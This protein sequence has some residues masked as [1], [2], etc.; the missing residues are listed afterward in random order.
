[1]PVRMLS[2]CDHHGSPE[3]WA[4]TRLSPREAGCIRDV[5]GRRRRIEGNRLPEGSWLDRFS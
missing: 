3:W 4:T 1:M 2:S 5:L